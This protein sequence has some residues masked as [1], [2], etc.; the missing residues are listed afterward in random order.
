MQVRV[1][2][3]YDGGHPLLA[4][5]GLDYVDF[6]GDLIGQWLGESASERLRRWRAD[7]RLAKGHVE[8]ALQVI[9]G[10]QSGLSRRWQHGVAT[11]TQGRLEFRRHW[12]R[13]FSTC[14]AID[15]VSV[16]GPARRSS[17]KEFWS[18]SPQSRI[19]QIET[20]TAILGWA[21]LDR[22]LTWAIDTLNSPA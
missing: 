19:T 10:S 9:S 14:P 17:N 2:M 12:W 18:L 21:V 4:S 13:A 8:C 20:P 11:V 16:R 22:H 5:A 7:R 6:L 15:V 3:P 1:L